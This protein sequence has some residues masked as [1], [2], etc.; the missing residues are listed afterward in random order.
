MTCAF[1]AFLRPFPSSRVARDE[2]A[3]ARAR[4]RKRVGGRSERAKSDKAVE[5]GMIRIKKVVSPPI[6]THSVSVRASVW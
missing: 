5:L 2:R 6:L 4:S 3:R 1:W